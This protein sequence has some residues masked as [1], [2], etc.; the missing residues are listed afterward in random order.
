[1]NMHQSDGLL[2]LICML[3]MSGYVQNNSGPKAQQNKQKAQKGA[4]VHKMWHWS[5][6]WY[7][8]V[9]FVCD[10]SEMYEKS[11]DMIFRCLNLSKAS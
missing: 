7:V 6:D 10:I 5:K 1:M 11:D 8:D 3:V 2:I 9:C 4:K